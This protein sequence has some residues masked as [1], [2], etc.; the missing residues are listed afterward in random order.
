MPFSL[1]SVFEK[2]LAGHRKYLLVFFEKSGVYCFL[3]VGER[4][5]LLLH[6]QSK[7]CF[8][9]ANGAVCAMIGGEAVEET[10]VIVA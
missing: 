10:G 5:T 3:N 7:D 8:V 1:L 2:G 4:F 6:F 9:L